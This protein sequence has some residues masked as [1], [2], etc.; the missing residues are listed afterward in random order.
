ME[1]LSRR[2]DAQAYVTPDAGTDDRIMV[3]GNI[4]RWSAEGRAT[5][6]SGHVQF[7]ELGELTSAMFDTA[8]PAIILSPLMGDDFDVMDVAERLSDLGF[9]GRYRVI[10]QA[11][12][13]VDMIRSEVRALAP[14]LDFDLL[15][16]PPKDS[17]G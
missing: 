1:D 9:Q 6:P 10:T 8:A 17:A 16:I 15:M 11:L 12:P 5:I 13:D 4:A 2:H 3:I 7:S 14:D